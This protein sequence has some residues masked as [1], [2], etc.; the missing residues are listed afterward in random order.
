MTLIVLALVLAPAFRG[1]WYPAPRTVASVV[2]FAVGAWF[3]VAGVG[4]LGRN[5][6]PYPKPLDDSALV[7]HGV[8]AWVRHP[9]YS[10]LM[11]VSVGWALLWASWAGL[12]VSG[13]LTWLLCAKARREE[14]WLRERYPAYRDYAQR[15]KRFVPGLW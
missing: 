11:F 13:V 4:A 1:L 3:G 14:R 10:S 7:Q 2:L 6:T 9:L 12:V 5:R 8:Y 15:V